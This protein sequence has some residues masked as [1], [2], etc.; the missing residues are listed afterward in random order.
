MKRFRYLI[1]GRVQGVCF[2]YFTKEEAQRLGLR[3]WVRNL[4]TGQVEAEVQGD[5]SILIKM[6]KV[7]RQGPAMAKVSEVN[8]NEI[9]LQEDEG[10]FYIC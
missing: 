10:D 9:L 7:L 2:R 4:T 8:S 3:G 6:N 5:E 1:S